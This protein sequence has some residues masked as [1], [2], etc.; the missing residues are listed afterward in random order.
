M[1]RKFLAGLAFAGAAIAVSA[2]GGYDPTDAVNGLNQ[3]L[4]SALQGSL[5]AAGVPTS[6]AQQAGITIDC[7]DSVSKGESFDCTVAGEASG[8]SVDVP[9]QVNDSDELVPVSQA[10]LDEG[11]ESVTQAE[12]N[13]FVVR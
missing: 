11:L 13:E 1:K 10:E 3:Q 9:M 7:P 2:C 4:N 8:V 6:K 5:E 12:T